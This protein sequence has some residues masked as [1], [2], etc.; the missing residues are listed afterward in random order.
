MPKS[1]LISTLYTTCNVFVTNYAEYL[2]NFEHVNVQGNIQLEDTF[3]SIIIHHNPTRKVVDITWKIEGLDLLVY[4]TSGHRRWPLRYKT[5]YTRGR[6]LFE[7][8]SIQAEQQTIMTN[9]M[10]NILNAFV[11]SNKF[12]SNL[13]NLP[14]TNLSINNSDVVCDSLKNLN[15]YGCKLTDE[16]IPWIATWYQQCTVVGSQKVFPTPDTITF[17]TYADNTYANCCTLIDSNKI[18]IQKNRELWYGNAEVQILLNKCQ[19][20]NGNIYSALSVNKDLREF[21]KDKFILGL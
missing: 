5:G 8:V 2:F 13:E 7:V 19:F 14:Y 16:I 10:T 21:A 12:L 18:L 1:E 11:I 15:V 4:E 3:G 20:Y 17:M 9:C 6:F